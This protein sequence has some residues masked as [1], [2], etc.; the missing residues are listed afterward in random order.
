MLQAA[1]RYW[2]RWIQCRSRICIIFE[3]SVN[4]KLTSTS[5]AR[6]LLL[7]QRE[8]SHRIGLGEMTDPLSF[9]PWRLTTD[10]FDPRVFPSTWVAEAWNPVYRRRVTRPKTS[11]K[12]HIPLNKHIFQQSGNKP[13][14]DMLKNK[15]KSKEKLG[16]AN[17]IVNQIGLV[18]YPTRASNIEQMESVQPCCHSWGKDK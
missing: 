15:N 6:T 13:L 4:E 12:L 5:W 10:G 17:E 7:G 8:S 3:A 18:L 11:H 1:L 2:V 9:Y 16:V 14:F